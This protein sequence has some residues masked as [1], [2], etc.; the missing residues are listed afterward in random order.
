MNKV[1]KFIVRVR[2]LGSCIE[3]LCLY[4]NCFRFHLLLKNVWPKA[5]PY[6][7]DGHVITKIGN[8][9]YDVK[10]KISGKGYWKMERYEQINAY[11][12][13]PTYDF[14]IHKTFIAEN[15]EEV[16]EVKEIK[17]VREVKAPKKI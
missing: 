16:T 2:A 7:N 11:E 13:K 17:E 1:E 4:G 10:G 12:W 6:Y 3:D 5:K 8:N 15:G 9:Y 14:R